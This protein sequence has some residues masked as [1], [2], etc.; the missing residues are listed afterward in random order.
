MLGLSAPNSLLRGHPQA[1]LR[2][3][4]LKFW[5]RTDPVLNAC[6]KCKPL[7]NNVRPLLPERN[8]ARPLP[9]LL[10]KRL[11]LRSPVRSSQRRRIFALL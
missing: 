3:F 6:L 7:R 1:P 8:N 10:P 9:P 2:L 5:R 11:P 4:R